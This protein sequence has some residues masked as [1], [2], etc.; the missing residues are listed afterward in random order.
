MNPSDPDAKNLFA[1][2]FTY[3]P[4]PTFELIETKQSRRR[5]ALE[6]FCTEAL[7]WCL[8]Q[9]KMFA[10]NLFAMLGV[11]LD[12]FELNTQLSFTGEADE[13]ADQDMR[14]RFDLV[15]KSLV[16]QSLIIFIECKVAFDRAEK[17]EQQIDEYR[18]HLRSRSFSRYRDKRIVLLTPFSDLHKADRHL[19]WSQVYDA[20]EQ[21]AKVDSETKNAILREFADFLKIRHLAKMKVPQI[22]PLLPSLKKVGPLLAGLESIFESLKNSEPG[23]TLFRRDALIPKMDWHEKDKK[24]WYGIWSRGA[25]PTYYVGFDTTDSGAEPLLMWVQVMVNGDRTSE[26]VPKNLK[27]W[28]NPSLSGPEDDGTTFVFT[29]QIDAEHDSAAAIEGW[30][31]TRLHDVKAWAE[32]IG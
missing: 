14:S 8:M 32:T 20:L 15:V 25:R 21:A 24:L 13:A 7:A 6:D 9:S 10:D 31:Q 11:H 19:S 27:K 2:L 26:A 3:A 30:L 1:R 12:T 28:H 16:P 4:R 18:H 22:T 29:Q 17:I 5:N 23:R